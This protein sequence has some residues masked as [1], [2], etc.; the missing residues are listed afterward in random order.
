MRI[1]RCMPKATNT[2]RLTI[3]NTYCFSTAT[4]FVGTRLDV[5]FY[6]RCVSRLF[7]ALQLPVGL[8]LREVSPSHSVGLPWTGDR[9]PLRPLPHNT[10]HSQQT[11]TSPERFEPEI[12]VVDGTYTYAWDGPATGIGII[13]LNGEQKLSDCLLFAIASFR[14][15]KHAGNM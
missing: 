1:S 4:V 10:Q 7:V 12:P 5:T 3:C 13:L 9:P 2:H 15:S 11:P 6:V 8:D 14:S